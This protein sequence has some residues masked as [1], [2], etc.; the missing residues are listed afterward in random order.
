MGN[1]CKSDLKQNIILEEFENF[2]ETFIGL[3][4]FEE[5][6]EAEEAKTTLKQQTPI[7]SFSKSLSYFLN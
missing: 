4:M 6:E 5:P 3:P 1:C 7:D 2:R